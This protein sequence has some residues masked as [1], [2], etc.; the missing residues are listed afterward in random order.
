M[1]IL[2]AGTPCPTANILYAGLAPGFAGLYQINMIVPPLTA[3]NPEIRI[4]FGPQISPPAV[5]LAAQ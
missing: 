3:P 1:Q 5:Q 2:L 4:A